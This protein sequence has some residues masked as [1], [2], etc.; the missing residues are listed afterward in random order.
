MFYCFTCSN[1]RR[2]DGRTFNLH[3][4]NNYAVTICIQGVRNFHS[5]AV[6]SISLILSITINIFF[7]V[8][9]CMT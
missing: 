2:F 9:N 4:L 6:F 8:H 3:V 5:I 1:A 7:C